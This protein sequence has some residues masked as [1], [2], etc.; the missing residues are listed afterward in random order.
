VEDIMKRKLVVAILLGSLGP[1][2][3]AEDTVYRKARLADAKG[4]QAKA[5]LIFSEARRTLAVEVASRT[6]AEV[7]YDSIDR[8]TYDYTKHHRFVAGAAAVS[9]A[10]VAGAAVMLTQSKSHWLTVEY[11]R[12]SVPETLVLRMD[13]RE[14]ERILDTAEI[15]TGRPVEY[16][17]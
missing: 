3:L 4:Q 9:L 8:L 11:H 6:V 15:Q 2:A 7:P 13:K 12:A 17:H 5:A 1:A 16:A 10:P 14:Y